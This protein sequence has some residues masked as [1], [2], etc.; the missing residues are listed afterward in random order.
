[1]SVA[2]WTAGQLNVA[3]PV[4][5][6]GKEGGKDL[7]MTFRNKIEIDLLVED[8]LALRTELDL[9]VEWK[10]TLPRTTH[11]ARRST[12][13]AVLQGR[14]E[15]GRRGEKKIYMS[16]PTHNYYPPAPRNTGL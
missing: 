4:R 11:Q 8:S 15:G 1:M 9:S 12:T 16:V 13:V 2:F 3:G 5:E 6:I 14:R 10:Q 7:F